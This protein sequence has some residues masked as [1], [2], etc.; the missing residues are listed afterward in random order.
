[1][2]SPS[3][4]PPAADTVYSPFTRASQSEYF[5]YTNST[6]NACWWWAICVLSSADAARN[7]RFSATA[8]VMGLVP[9]T[10]KDVAWPER[11][12]VLISR[13]LPRHIETIIRA[14]GIVPSIYTSAEK[15]DQV[16]FSSMWLY[17]WTQRLSQLQMTLLL[18]INTLVLAIAYAALAI[19]EVYSKRSSLGCTYPV[20]ILTWYLIAVFPAAVDTAFRQAGPSGQHEESATMAASGTSRSSDPAQPAER[21]TTHET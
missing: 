21:P 6:N 20:F 5:A 3:G 8:L 13:P 18:A 4:C 10:L 1:M 2:A 14:L 17:R 16:T 11:R 7:Q 19:M 9:L 15:T 12:V